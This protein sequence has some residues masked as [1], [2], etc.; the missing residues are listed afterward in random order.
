[1]L[2]SIYSSD[3]ANLLGTQSIGNISNENYTSKQTKLK[4]ILV[5]S[6]VMLGLMASF[7][8]AIYALDTR[9]ATQLEV[10][11]ANISNTNKTIT[12]SSA[13]NSINGTLSTAKNFTIKIESLGVDAEISP[14]GLASDGSVDVPKNNY[15]VGYY[16]GS[17]PLGQP[18]S[19]LLVG[20][21]ALGGGAVFNNIS[22]LKVGSTFTVKDSENGNTYEY[23]VVSNQ[24]YLVEDLPMEEIL[25]PSTDKSS[26]VNLITCGGSYDGSDFSE[27][28]LIKAVIVK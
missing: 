21:Y 8:G 4:R 14:V 25:Q 11:S 26:V 7:G 1:M 23:S 18:G 3:F 27:R 13:Q 24:N 17:T 2:Q 10:N 12:P 22:S 15:S 6:L 16:N 9:E 28:T 19:S 5:L 20:H